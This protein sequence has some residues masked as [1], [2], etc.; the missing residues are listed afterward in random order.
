VPK[1]DILLSEILN[2]E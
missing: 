1:H 2:S